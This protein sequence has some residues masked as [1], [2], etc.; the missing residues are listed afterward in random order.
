MSVGTA[1]NPATGA[2]P[3]PD[4][5]KL[6]LFYQSAVGKKAVMA[7]TGLIGFG[8]VIGHMLGNLQVFLGPEVMNGYGMALHENPVLLYGTRAVLLIAVV[9]HIV[10]AVQLINMNRSAR[11]QGYAKLSPVVSSYASRTMRWSGPILAVFIVYHLLHFTFGTAH[12]NFTYQDTMNTVP[13][14]Y[15]NVV[16]GFANPLVSL[17]YIVSMIL[18]MLH[19][20]HGAWSLFQSLG[21]NHP[22]YTPLI[23]TTA[24]AASIALLIGNCSIPIAV[25]AGVVK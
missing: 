7:V 5:G 25:L 10:A 12:P 9:L 3:A 6:L 4:T 1:A 14:P 19:I 22:R 15:E 2:K 20:H 8:F 23:R 16:R 24:R 21:L 13:A 17:F 18:L 11:P